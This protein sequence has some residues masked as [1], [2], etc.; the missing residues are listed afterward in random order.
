MLY[1]SG[2][3]TIS[4]RFHALREHYDHVTAVR[5]V[6]VSAIGSISPTHYAAFFRDTRNFGVSWKS[7]TRSCEDSTPRTSTFFLN[8]RPQV[9]HLLHHRLSFLT[10]TAFL[11]PFPQSSLG[12]H[13]DRSSPAT[14]TCPIP[15]STRSGGLGPDWAQWQYS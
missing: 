1:L 11:S 4:C 9:L 13:A 6:S 8:A 15:S 3:N 7:P 12:R 14:V 10:L 2:N 5:I